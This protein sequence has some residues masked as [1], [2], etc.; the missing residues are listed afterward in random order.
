MYARRLGGLH[1][2]CQILGEHFQSQKREELSA[3]LKLAKSTRAGV[4]YA[5]VYNPQAK[6]SP[7]ESVR[8][9]PGT[10]VL[11]RGCCMPSQG[12]AD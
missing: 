7:Y 12:V 2:P 8:A 10:R 11:G 1:R 9:I 5:C 3:K 6:W 4:K